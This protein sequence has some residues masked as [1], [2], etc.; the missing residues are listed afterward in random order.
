M[1]EAAK[2]SPGAIRLVEYRARL[3]RGLRPITFDC[4]FLE[5]RDALWAHGYLDNPHE[6][7]PAV[8]A[9]ALAEVLPTLFD[10]ATAMARQPKAVQ[11]QILETVRSHYATSRRS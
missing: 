11:E 3:K 1:G 5:T 7:D 8:V 2:K 10:L 9:K 4:D 6:T